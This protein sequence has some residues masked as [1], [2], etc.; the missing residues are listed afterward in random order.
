MQVALSG[1]LGVELGQ[2]S[3]HGEGVIPDHTRHRFWFGAVALGR[4]RFPAEAALGLEVDAGAVIPLTR[5][6]FVIEGPKTKVF[7]PPSIA[8]VLGLGLSLRV[9]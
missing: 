5:D 4:L 2:L 7:Q 3:A 9:L 6:R 1:C 8:L